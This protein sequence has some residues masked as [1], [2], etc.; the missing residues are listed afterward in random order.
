MS[1]QSINSAT[2]TQEDSAEFDF[3]LIQ[4]H[5]DETVYSVNNQTL[6]REAQAQQDE[7]DYNVH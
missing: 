3:I 7:S 1:N 2:Q 4:T 6:V 5:G